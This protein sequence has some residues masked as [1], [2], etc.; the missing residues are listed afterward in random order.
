MPEYEFDG[1][2]GRV[3]VVLPDDGTEGQMVD[4]ARSV[5]R[6]EKGSI[7]PDIPDEPACPKPLTPE[8]WKDAL[9]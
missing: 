8:E 9:Q 2:P 3:H 7:L 4:K 1:R 6:A 5:G